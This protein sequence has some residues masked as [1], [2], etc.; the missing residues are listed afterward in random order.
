MR[1]EREEPGEGADEAE[2]AVCPVCGEPLQ[3]EK[4]KVVCRS[5]TCV[6]RIVYNCAEF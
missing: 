1:G 3:Q 6:Y 2:R 4:C 5:A